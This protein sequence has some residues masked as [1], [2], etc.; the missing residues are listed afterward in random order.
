MIGTPVPERTAARRN[1]L[2]P[3]QHGAKRKGARHARIL[4]QPFEKLSELQ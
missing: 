4:M 3:T 2:R 1:T